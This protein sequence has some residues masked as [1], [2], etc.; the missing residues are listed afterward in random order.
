[1]LNF[2]IDFLT[3]VQVILGI[4]LQINI[5]SNIVFKPSCYDPTPLLQ[6]CH[7]IALYLLLEHLTVSL[8][9]CSLHLYVWPAVH[10][11]RHVC[12]LPTMVA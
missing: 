1:M 10:H 3:A 7:T 8:S 4:L 11:T 2:F 5:C 6:N 12:H 9:K